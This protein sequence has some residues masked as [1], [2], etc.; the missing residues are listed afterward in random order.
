MQQLVELLS[1]KDVAGKP[2]YS[3]VD[4]D[5]VF[6][7]LA[8]Q[9]GDE[10]DD[11]LPPVLEDLVAK[12]AAR[13]G[14]TSAMPTEEAAARFH[15]ELEKNP[16]HPDLWRAVRRILG[17]KMEPGAPELGAMELGAKTAALLGKQRD[18]PPQARPAGG[19]SL[20]DVLAEKNKRPDK[21]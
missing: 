15:R 10:S 2:K 3:Q 8:V 12:F 9:L 16:V 20:L 5:A 6:V 21:K 13:A 14:V 17:F 18:A 4:V 19:R 7:M 11:P 1:H